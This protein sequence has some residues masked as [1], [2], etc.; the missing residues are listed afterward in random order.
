MEHKDFKYHAKRNSHT[1]L[2]EI[3]FWTT[4]INNWQHLLKKDENKMIAIAS[5]QW[6]VEKKLVKI[7]GYVIMPNHIHLIWEQL[8]L[9]GKELP[10]NSF[11]KFTAKSLLKTLQNNKETALKNYVFDGID[12]QYN[13][14]QRDPLAIPLFNSETTAQKLNY[15][16]LNP[17][18]PHW[19]LCSK[20]AEYRFSSAIFYEQ[21]IDEFGLLTHFGTV[22]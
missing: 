21:Q 22:F 20:P 14:W 1:D 13:I 11:E 6:L 2:N 17:L 16:H 8:K 10:K 3:Y 12:R 9:N 19:L 7:Y 5:L 15:I 4:T 18:Q